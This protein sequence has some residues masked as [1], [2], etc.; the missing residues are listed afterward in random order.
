[1]ALLRRYLI[2][3]RQRFN[4]GDFASDFI[5]PSGGPHVNLSVVFKTL[6]NVKKNTLAETWKNEEIRAGEA[7]TAQYLCVVED[8]PAI[9]STD[10]CVLPILAEISCSDEA[11]LAVHL[12]PERNLLVWDIP[13]A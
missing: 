8:A 12:I 3:S 1:M 13:E 7:N 11:R 10:D 9:I 2:L 4:A 6:M 5:P